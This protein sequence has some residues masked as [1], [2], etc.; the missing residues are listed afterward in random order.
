MT[1]IMKKFEG[2][3]CSCSNAKRLISYFLIVTFIGVG[4]HGIWKAAW[5]LELNGTRHELP[6][7][8]SLN[9][10]VGT[11]RI[12]SHRSR[13]VYLSLAQYPEIK[14]EIVLCGWPSFMN[15]DANIVSF[16][17]SEDGRVYKIST[18]KKTLLS[19]REIQERYD[20]LLNSIA[21]D[22]LVTSFSFLA[23]FVLRQCFKP[24]D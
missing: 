10:V 23:L 20:D 16:F 12:E 14:C 6:P 21:F 18:N 8:D 17:V 7:E 3:Q 1:V 5:Y 11:L 24:R 15:N 13:P 2:R 19:Y 9:E 4:I 22:L